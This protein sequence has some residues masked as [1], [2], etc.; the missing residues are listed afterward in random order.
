[1]KT[2][3]ESYK[4]Q[5]P[6]R[7]AM[8][9]LAVAAVLKDGEVVTAEAV[10]AQL[11]TD[12]GFDFRQDFLNEIVSGET[13]TPAPSEAV[14]DAD[15]NGEVGADDLRERCK[16]IELEAASLRAAIYAGRNRLTTARG[17]LANAIGAFTAGH[18]HVSVQDNIRRELAASLETR[19]AQSR[20]DDMPPAVQFGPS[21]LDR[22]AGYSGSPSGLHTAEDH[23]RGRFSNGGFR[24]GS[25]PAS[26]KNAVT[27]LK[28]PQG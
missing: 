5:N 17:N 16:A 6:D 13:G 3:F 4:L 27:R 1:M 18:A 25:Y 9:Q 28:K 24:R 26:T 19:A 23:V 15:F 2:P 12:F 7:V 20:G 8:I 21:T 14:D 10:K 22:S 11:P